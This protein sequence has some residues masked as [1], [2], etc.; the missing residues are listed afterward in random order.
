[1]LRIVSLLLSL[2]AIQG[3]AMFYKPL[4]V[5]K[6]VDLQRY[7]GKWYEIARY[8]HFFERGCAGVT[9][10]Y[11][12][13]EDGD[14]RVVNTC[15]KGGLDGPVKDIEGYAW[16]ADEKTNAKL[17]VRFFWPFYGSYWILEV[18]ED[19][20]WAVV[21]HPSRS[22]FWILSRKPRMGAA[23]YDSILKKMP[24]W[25]YKPE[26]LIKVEQLSSASTK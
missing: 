20:S 23:V 1:M 2:V 13:R 6:K 9:A 11:S 5:E 26:K 12:L 25:G 10:E 21:G 17:K 15:R 18:A 16:V 22:Y 4:P 3:C 7:L 8:P 24:G 14:I 19:Y